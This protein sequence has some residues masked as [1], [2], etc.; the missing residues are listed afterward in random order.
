VEVA[1]EGLVVA[2]KLDGTPARESEGGWAE[3]LQGV[4][5]DLLR[6]LGQDGGRLEEGSR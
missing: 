5:G 4:E 6:G 1:G 2:H 3:N